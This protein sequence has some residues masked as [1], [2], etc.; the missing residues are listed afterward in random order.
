MFTFSHY[1]LFCLEADFR[2]A[3]CGYKNVYS[4]NFTPTEP[5]EKLHTF[6][7]MLRDF[8]GHRLVAK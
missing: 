7:N 5:P 2:C 4:G 8:E 1:P 6:T 3:M